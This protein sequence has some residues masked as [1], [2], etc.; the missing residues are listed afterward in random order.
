MIAAF[1]LYKIKA[2]SDAFVHTQ[3][4]LKTFDGIVNFIQKQSKHSDIKSIE[5][6]ADKYMSELN[7]KSCGG[8]RLNTE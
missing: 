8:S 4:L 6:W 2:F 3:L 1:S 7:C 5:K